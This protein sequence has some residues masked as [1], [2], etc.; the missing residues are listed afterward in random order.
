MQKIKLAGTLTLLLPYAVEKS[1]RLG[2]TRLSW[3]I[4]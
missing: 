3:Q 1:N 4:K 2:L